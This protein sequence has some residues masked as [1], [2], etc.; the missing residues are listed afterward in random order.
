MLSALWIVPHVR[1]RSM[2]ICCMCETTIKKAARV[3][4]TSMKSYLDEVVASSRFLVT[5]FGKVSFAAH[6]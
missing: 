6:T 3:R 2:I 4:V 5:T 1:G